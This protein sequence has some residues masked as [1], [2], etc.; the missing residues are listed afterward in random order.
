MMNI[1]MITINIIRRIRTEVGILI[2]LS[3]YNSP[4]F[5]PNKLEIF[6]ISITESPDEHS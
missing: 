1:M 2:P 3:I 5:V 6:C 4:A